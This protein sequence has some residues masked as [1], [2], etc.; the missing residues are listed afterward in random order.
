VPLNVS[1]KRTL[2]SLLQQLPYLKLFTLGLCCLPPGPTYHFKGALYRGV[3][4]SRRANYDSHDPRMHQIECAF[5]TTCA[6][7]VLEVCLLMPTCLLIV[8]SSA[9]V[10]C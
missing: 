10:I 9:V 2:P 7:D 6:A 3:D 8:I 5:P 4:I 1:G